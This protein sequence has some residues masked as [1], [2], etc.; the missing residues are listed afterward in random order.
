MK[1]KSNSKIGKVEEN[2]FLMYVPVIIHK[3]YNV[4]DKNIVTLY[5]EHNKLVEK[6]ARWLANKNNVSDIELD[7]KSS[8]AWLLIDGKKNIYEIALEMA[9]V[10]GDTQEIAIERLVLFIRYIL[11][12]KWIKLQ[13]IQA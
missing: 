8:A 10:C 9:E 11:R 2:N 1:G 12:K 5:F 7:E 4:D 13:I 3:N 6:F